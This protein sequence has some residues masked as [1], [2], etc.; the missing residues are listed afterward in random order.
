MFQK[1]TYLKKEL[2]QLNTQHKNTHTHT[3]YKDSIARSGTE[4]VKGKSVVR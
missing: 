4:S 2:S 3:R 1:A